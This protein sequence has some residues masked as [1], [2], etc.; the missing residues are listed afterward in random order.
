MKSG[1]DERRW[2]DEERTGRRKRKCVESPR[3]SSNEEGP[4]ELPLGREEKKEEGV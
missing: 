3:R 4:P 2:D 1:K